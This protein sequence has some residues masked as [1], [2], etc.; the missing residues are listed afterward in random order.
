MP[1]DEEQRLARIGQAAEAAAQ[2][3][4][5]IRVGKARI[6]FLARSEEWLSRLVKW[7]EEK[8]TP[9]GR[10][11][12]NNLRRQLEKNH[13]LRAKLEAK[14]SGLDALVKS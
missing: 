9:A 13:S 5:E 4:R 12:A 10:E 8:K 2:A 7:A 3:A 6:E 1:I 11:V 14:C